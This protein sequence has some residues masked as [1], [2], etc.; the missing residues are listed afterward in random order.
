MLTAGA[1]SYSRDARD[2]SVLRAP[3][4]CGGFICTSDIARDRSDDSRGCLAEEG[5]AGFAE[6][7]PEQRV[8]FETPDTVEV[9]G[10]RYW[11]DAGTQSGLQ[12]VMLF[13]DSLRTARR[14]E[15]I[16]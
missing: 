3:P 1:R 11:L 9:A 4:T 12:L 6:S 10:G 14:K 7:P 16:T 13:S 15:G 8:A 5:D 2:K